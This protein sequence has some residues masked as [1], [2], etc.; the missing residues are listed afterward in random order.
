MSPVRWLAAALLVAALAAGGWWWGRD[1]D[2]PIAPPSF[3]GSGSCAS[4][5]ADQ[6]AAWKS[7]QHALAMQSADTQTVAGNFDD[8]VFAAGGTTA[9]FFR[10]DKRFVVNTD[11]PDGRLADF[12][13]KYTFGV[14]PLQQ[15]LVELPGGRLQALGIAWDA[16]P[17][18]EGGQRWFHLYPDR[19]LRAGD[20]LHWTGIDQNWNYQCADCHS[21]NV[22]KNYDPATASFSTSWSEISVGCEACHGPASNHLRWARREPG[23]RALEAGRGLVNALDERRGASWSQTA[24]GSVARSTARSSSREID[25]CARCHARR[26]QFSDAIH[27]GEPWLDGFR[28]ALLEPGL[29]HADGQQRDEVFSWGSFLQS[30]MHAAGVTCSDCHE[31]HGGKLRVAGNGVCAQCHA[32]AVFDT[33]AHHHHP[34][35]SPGAECVACHM[36]ATTYM[37]VDPRHDHSLRIPRPDRSLALGTPNACNQCHADRDAQWAADAVAGWYPQRKPGFQGFVETFAAADRGEPVLPELDAVA[38]D[39]NQ[40]ALVRAS[41]L[42]RLRVFPAAGTADRMLAALRDPDAVVRATA[43]EA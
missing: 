23:W 21:T 35:A 39:S 19:Q 43:A 40:P 4:C 37:I 29:Y 27:A 22:R 31:P 20:P 8:A 25:A 9:R 30:R 7:S 26:G 5:H 36:P 1:V 3:A 32:P 17:A 12:D 24:A 2:A 28:P 11:G 42:A 10:R 18:A 41:A 6:H 33:S 13:L 14:Y 34:A 38:G 15:Y 16:R